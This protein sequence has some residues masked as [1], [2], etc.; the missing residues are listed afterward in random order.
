MDSIS[1]SSGQEDHV[2]MGGF[3][4]R[5]ALQVVDNVEHV[6]LSLEAVEYVGPCY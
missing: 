2:S 1:T 5:K 6:S 3:C 4:A